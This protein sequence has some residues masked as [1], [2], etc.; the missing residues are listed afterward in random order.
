MYVGTHCV[1]YV[2]ALV[3]GA[4]LVVYVCMCLHIC[5]SYIG[6]H[7]QKGNALCDYCVTKI[8]KQKGLPS[9]AL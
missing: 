5:S 8:A 6:S 4:N 7:S 9:P 1:C 2:Q 3:Y